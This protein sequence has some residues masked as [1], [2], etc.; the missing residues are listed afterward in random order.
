[1]ACAVA[2]D[3]IRFVV[4]VAVVVVAVAVAVLL[5]LFDLCAA[6]SVTV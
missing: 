1:M 2:Y 3:L 4:V 5:L 6:V